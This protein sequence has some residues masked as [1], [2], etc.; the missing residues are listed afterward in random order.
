M[1]DGWLPADRHKRQEYKTKLTLIGLFW[2]IF[3]AFTSQRPFARLH[4]KKLKLRPLD[5]A[6]LGITTYRLGRLTAYDKVTEPLRWPFVRTVEDETGAGETVEPRGK[7]TQ[8]ALGELLSCPICSGTW[9]A[10]GLVYGLHL[11][12]GPTRIF[13][14][15]IGSVGFAELL[16]ALTEALSWTGQAAR[17]IAGSPTQYPGKGSTELDETPGAQERKQKSRRYF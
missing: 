7:G 1:A 16:N 14:T 4:E 13:M 2:G 12:P 10:S 8:K 3:V 5:L 6:L 9:I 17:K 11:I 15:I